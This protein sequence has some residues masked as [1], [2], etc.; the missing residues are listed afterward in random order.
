MRGSLLPLL[1]CACTLGAC[2]SG[3]SGPDAGADSG[4]PP[5][6]YF[7]LQKGRCFE[8]TTADTVQS[9]PDLGVV[10]EET[11]NGSFAVPT[12]VISYNTG[13]I[14]MKDYVAFDGSAMMLYKREFMGGKSYIYDPPLMRL[15]A[16]LK[17]GST[18][19]A[20]AKVTIR[21]ATGSVLVSSE[22]HDLRVDVFDKADVKLP[23][24]QTVSASKLAFTETVTATGA[25]GARAEY[26]TFVP[27]DGS[28][29]GADGFVTINFNFESDEGLSPLEYRLQKV[30]DLGD[31]PTQAIP[32]CGGIQ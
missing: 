12:S 20:S 1:L 11:G 2:G 6:I 31:N 22:P 21:D 30:R 5:E 24:G 19:Q 14:A 29:T 13:S 32:P 9:T 17:P 23:V 18:Q 26:R 4:V 27:G 8:Y 28:R 16:P 25:S 7:S 3:S 10:V 15:Q